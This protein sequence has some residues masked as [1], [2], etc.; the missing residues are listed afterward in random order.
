MFSGSEDALSLESAQSYVNSFFYCNYYEEIFVCFKE[1]LY[2]LGLFIL[3]SRKEDCSH[4]YIFVLRITLPRWRETQFSLGGYC[5]GLCADQ[6][7]CQRL[8][9]ASSSLHASHQLTL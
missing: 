1:L 3:I 4:C 2:E 8:T 9:L 7:D 6:R 5:P